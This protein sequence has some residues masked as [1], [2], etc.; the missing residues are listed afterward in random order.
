MERNVEKTKSLIEGI[1]EDLAQNTPITKVFNKVQIL[2]NYLQNDAFTVWVQNERMG[3]TDVHQLPEYRKT[4][5]D[6]LVDGISGRYSLTKYPIPNGSL[7]N[8]D[9]EKAMRVYYCFEKISNLEP[10]R[11]KPEGVSFLVLPAVAYPTIGKIFPNGE[12]HVAYHKV[13][14][15]FFA[16]VVDAVNSKLL[17]FLLKLNKEMEFDVD[18]NMINK[19]TYIDMVANQTINAGVVNMGSGNVAI[20]NS[21]VIG[22]YNNTMPIPIEWKEKIRNI[23]DEIDKIKEEDD[24]D[25][26]DIAREIITIKDELEKENASSS[27]IKR[28]FRVLK[29]FK[30]IVAEKAIEY[31]IEQI[32]AMI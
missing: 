23:L 11:E 15:L 26:E 24:A 4:N 5:V 9:L 10:F 13:P 29:S 8:E 32:I 14:N 7:G 19:K 30:P 25:K 31:G 21:Q 12:I 20:D 2:A 18:F 27:I 1:I 17:D 22:G 16:G 28:A 6:I 3:Y